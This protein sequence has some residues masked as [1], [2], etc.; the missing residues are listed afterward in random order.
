MTNK[1]VTISPN[2]VARH[3]FFFFFYSGQQFAP[4]NKQNISKQMDGR[5][6]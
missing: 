2:K 4:A 1:D 6:D 5:S 3:F